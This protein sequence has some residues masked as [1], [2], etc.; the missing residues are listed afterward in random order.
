MNWF[1]ILMFGLAVFFDA[2]MDY[3]NFQVAYDSGFWSL[4]TEGSKFDAWHTA[5]V[6]KWTCVVF[7]VIGKDN[8]KLSTVWIYGSINYIVH[9]VVYH[10]ILKRRG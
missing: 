7:A 2:V 5:K 8:I 9:E 6:L 4:H 3:F 10:K 1:K